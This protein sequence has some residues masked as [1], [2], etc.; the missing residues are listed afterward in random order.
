MKVIVCFGLALLF[1]GFSQQ[2]AAVYADEDSETYEILLRSM[3]IAA[4]LIAV[5]WGVPRGVCNAISI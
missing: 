3:P 2:I 5:C 4:A 1:A